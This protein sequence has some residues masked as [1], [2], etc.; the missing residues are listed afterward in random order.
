MSL[1]TFLRRQRHESPRGWPYDPR[2]EI[3]VVVSVILFALALVLGTVQAVR[4]HRAA[5]QPVS[6][7]ATLGCAPAGATTLTPFA[8]GQ[9]MQ[10]IGV[11]FEQ[12]SF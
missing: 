1:T 7:P 4:R 12:A 6:V 11:Q 10:M 9:T 2:E 3:L 5:A 8:P